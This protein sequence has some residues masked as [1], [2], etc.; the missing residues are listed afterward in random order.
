[1]NGEKINIVLIDYHQLYREGMKRVIQAEEAFE[2]LVSSDD[3][4]VVTQL[5]DSHPIDVL[6]I[7][8]KI[9]MNNSQHIK[10]SI[11]EASPTIK[12][13]VMSTEGEENFVTEAIRIGVHGYLLKEMDIFSFID[14][15]KSVVKGTSYIHPIITHDLVEEYRK[16][17]SE[18]DDYE[19]EPLVQWP[20]HLYTK[21]ECEVLQLLA[22]GQSNRRIAE[23]LDISEKTVKNHVSSLFKKMNVNDRTQ[24]VVTAI[25]NHWVEI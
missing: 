5:L 12:V 15:I 14:A 20:L 6:L 16:L 9:F 11:I 10:Q 25:R 17:S 4:S 13:V 22:N 7:D 18:G 2:I 8:I 19:D 21:R 24:A 23:T 3:Y 1:M